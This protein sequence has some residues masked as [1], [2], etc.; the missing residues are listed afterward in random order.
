[1]MPEKIYS[2]CIRCEDKSANLYL[3]L[4][5]RFCDYTDLSWFWV[6]M[7][8]REKQ[9]AGLLHYC[10][11]NRVF[12]QDLPDPAVIERLERDLDSLGS[13]AS[14]PQVTVDAAFEIAIQL[15]SCGMRDIRLKLTEPIQGPAHVQR[16]K[17]EISSESCGKLRTAAER[18]AL[19]PTVRTRLADLR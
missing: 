3:D 10:F 2:D 7:A 15:E 11:E 4:S 6:E 5:V 12:S 18:F 9:S 14:D 13:Q 8:M 19:S 1:M 17:L 16:K